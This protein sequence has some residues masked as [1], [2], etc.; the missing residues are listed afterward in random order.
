MGSALCGSKVSTATELSIQSS[1]FTSTLPENQNLTIFFDEND[2]IADALN[3][4]EISIKCQNLLTENRFALLNPVVHIFVE[5]NSE[6]IKKAETEVIMKTLNPMFLTKIKFLYS[7]R[8]TQKLKFEIYDFQFQTKTKELIG[9]IL[10]SIHEIVKPGWI[11]KDIIK[12]GKKEGTI[13]ISSTE[14]TYLNDT[15]KMHWKLI[16]QKNYGNCILRIQREED[17]QKFTVHQT[18]SQNF[19]YSIF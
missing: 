2:S 8:C 18:E 7:L 5:S 10:T 6:F 1:R 16:T 15:I 17:K 19:P 12:R 11:S 13:T 14:L 9:S 4:V 3:L